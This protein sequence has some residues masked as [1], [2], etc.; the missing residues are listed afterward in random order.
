MK[1]AIVILFALIVSSVLFVFPT[2]KTA[3][4]ARFNYANDY[5]VIAQLKSFSDRHGICLLLVHHTR[6]QNAGDKFDM[7]IYAK[8]IP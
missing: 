7:Y 1:K 4:A 2:P 6:K 5:E 3:Y 8:K